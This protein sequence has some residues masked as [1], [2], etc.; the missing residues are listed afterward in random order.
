[1]S[2]RE[3]LRPA[4]FRGVAFKVT[5]N[6]G[7]FGRRVAV[8]EYPFRDLP[9]VEDLGRRAREIRI[10]A[11]LIGNDYMAGRDA[12]IAAVEDA[13][14]G[15]LVHPTLGELTVSVL[16]GGMNVDE[17]TEQGGMCRISFS[18]IE[19]GEAR[20]PS[21]S[22]ATPVVVQQRAAAA[23]AAAANAFAGGF[24]MGG[25][26]AWAQ[27]SAVARAQG[28]LDAIQ[29]A[30]SALP[31]GAPARGQVAALAA[32][33]SG[34]LSTAL[35][36]PA[37]FAGDV[38]GVVS[39][40]RAGITASAAVPLLAGLATFGAGASHVPGSTP[41]RRREASNDAA[42]IELARGTAAIER[43]RA[44]ADMPFPDY[45][46]ALA[47]RDSVLA[48]LDTVADTTGNDQLCDALIALRAAVVRDVAA[49]GANLARVVSMTPPA[50]LPALVLAYDLYDD[51]TREGE[52]VERKRARHPG[53]MA[54]A[55]PLEVSLDA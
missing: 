24:D 35:R 53:F 23:N 10:E 19:S 11:L 16:D 22:A 41:T 52:L 29:H 44:L 14:P 46:A 48:Q 6:S 12:L 9:Y 54:G 30:V 3:Q 1:M 5:S 34:R 4:S 33:L 13:G 32:D 55:Q 50:T 51:A 27:G 8:H 47:A 38:A 21:A 40:M 45:N 31:N 28:V 36:S 2:W 43:A 37:A 25:L 39:A 18:C 26:P 7:S 15:K 42:L 49:R 17:S 20:F